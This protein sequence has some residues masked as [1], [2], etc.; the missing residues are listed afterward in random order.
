MRDAV[1]GTAEGVARSPE[2]L[3]EFWS[4]LGEMYARMSPTDLMASTLTHCA[5]ELR[6]SLECRAMVAR[7][8]AG[9]TRESAPPVSARLVY[10]IQRPSANE[11]KIGISSDPES[12]LA[13]LRSASGSPLILVA[14]LDGGRSRELELHEQFAAHRKS[15]EWFHE[16]PEITEW[17]AGL[18]HG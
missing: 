14:V 4:G 1:I 3:V 7:K 12:R 18:S 11:V 6:A 5:N 9:R 15:G 13:G 16:A 8:R 17:I 10:V 2:Q